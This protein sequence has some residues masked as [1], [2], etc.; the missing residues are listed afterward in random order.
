[1][2]FTSGCATYYKDHT[3]NSPLPGGGNESVTTHA[4][5]WQLFPSAEA[6]PKA[7]P[8]VRRRVIVCRQPS[9]GS[10]HYRQPYRTGRRIVVVRYHHHY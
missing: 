4:I 3:I 8:S 5:G 1:V 7:I 6:N 10:Y 2:F 9:Y